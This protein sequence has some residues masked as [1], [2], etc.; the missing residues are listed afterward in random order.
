MRRADGT[1]SRRSEHNAIVLLIHGH[2]A[3]NSRIIQREGYT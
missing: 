1:T 3:P 2:T